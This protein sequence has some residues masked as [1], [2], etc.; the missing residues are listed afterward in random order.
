M[1]KTVNNANLVQQCY[2]QLEKD[3]I[4]NTLVPGQKL[5]IEELKEQLAIG[6]S[7]IREALSRLVASGLVEIEHNRGFYVAAISQEDIRDIYQTFIDIENL[8]LQKSIQQGDD[9]WAANIV[10]SL[11]ELSLIES[12]GAKVESDEWLKRNYAFH[13]A[14]IAGC[15]S[16]AL[17]QIRDNLYR[18]FDRYCRMGFA[19]MKKSLEHNHTSHKE[20]AEAVLNRDFKNASKLMAHHI[21]GSLETVIQTLKKNKLIN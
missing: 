15:N 16:P 8:A 2:G 7:P 12:K 21:S 13:K 20:L 6:H 14:L 4:N 1:A 9:R 17:L 11:Y 10:A 5:R 19:T 18:R 3:I